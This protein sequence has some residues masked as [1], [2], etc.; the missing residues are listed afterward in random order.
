MNL[1]R[2]LASDNP[3]DANVRV[4]PQANPAAGTDFKITVP[5]Q[6]V[7]QLYALTATLTTSATVANRTPAL[8]ITDGTSIVTQVAPGVALTATLTTV[9]SWLAEGPGLATSIVGGVLNAKVPPTILQPGWTVGPVTGLIDTTDQWS[10]IVL[11]VVEVF[12]GDVEHDRYDAQKIID[13]LDAIA[14]L[15]GQR[16]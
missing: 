4:L 3:T 2:E 15:L 14:V 9:V 13:R 10:K 16:S 5:G 1:L 11:T 12:V 7:W 6:S 8:N